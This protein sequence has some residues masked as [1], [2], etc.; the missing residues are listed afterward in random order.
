MQRFFKAI[1]SD[2]FRILF[3]YQAQFGLRIGEAVKLNAKNINFQTKELA[4]KTEKAR[5]IDTLRIPV[6]LFKQTLA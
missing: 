3:S 2:K 4:L 1:E 5:I 6:Q